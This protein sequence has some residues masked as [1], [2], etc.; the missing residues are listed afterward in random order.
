[1]QG[2]KIGIG[3]YKPL[4]NA[5]NDLKILLP[6]GGTTISGGSRL[7]FRKLG[8]I[9]V[10]LTKKNCTNLTG[11]GTSLSIAPRPEKSLPYSQERILERT[12][13]RRGCKVSGARDCM[14]SS[15][16]LELYKLHQLNP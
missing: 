11:H 16:R 2:Q 15:G 1:M 5:V 8:T 14:Y 12:M 3:F 13:F 9:C 4:V 7:L 6:A 10:H